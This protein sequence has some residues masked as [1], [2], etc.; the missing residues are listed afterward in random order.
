MHEAIS[1]SDLMSRRCRGAAS[2]A[3]GSMAAYAPSLALLDRLLTPG[4][5]LG[6]L[7]A[8]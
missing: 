4:I 3:S 5:P 7:T 8:T 6:M 1:Q 2:A